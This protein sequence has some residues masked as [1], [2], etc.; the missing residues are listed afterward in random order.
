MTPELRKQ[1]K[2]LKKRILILRRHARTF[3]EEVVVNSIKY[4]VQQAEKVFKNH[5]N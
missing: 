5:N 4:A 1:L 3:E 2:D